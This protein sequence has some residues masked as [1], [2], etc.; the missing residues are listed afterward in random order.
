MKVWNTLRTTYKVGDFIDWQR[1]GSLILNPDFQRGSVWSGGAKSYLIDTILRGLPIPIIFLRDKKP[2]LKKFSAL[3]EVVDGQQR[4]RTVIAYIA[5]ELLSDFDN[6]KDNFKI[7]RVHNEEFQGKRFSDLPE[8]VQQHILDYQFSVDVFPSDTGDREVKQVFQRMNSSGYKL[9]AQELR[10]AEFFGA[11]KTKVET[12]A[13]EQLE[14]WRAWRILTP[15][16]L[17]RMIDVEFTSELVIAMLRGIS[18]K[19][20]KIIY[21]IYREYDDDFPFGDEVGR[22]FQ[23]VFDTIARDFSN[24]VA[25]SFRTRTLF[26]ALFMAVYGLHFGVD[27]IG[28]AGNAPMELTPKRATPLTRAAIDH[29]IKAGDRINSKSAPEEVMA[30][31]TRRVSH[32]RERR[33]I[34]RYLLKMSQ[35]V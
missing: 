13:T 27:S 7:R 5:P 8:E 12:L 29:I 2:D 20:D 18:E 21:A 6:A 26:Y 14:R 9:N 22:R 4:L 3:R 11:F 34:V 28:L 23:Q 25:E 17:V 31:S 35:H 30:A 33:N 19:T 32:V 1:S 16:N 24:V 10:N 15:D